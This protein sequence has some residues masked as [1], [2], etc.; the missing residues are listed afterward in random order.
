MNLRLKMVLGSVLLASVVLVSLVSPG[1]AF[2]V[3]ATDS[4]AR[5]VDGDTFDTYANGRVRLADVDAPESYEP[6]FDGATDALEGMIGG[7]MVFLDID[8]ISRTDRFGRLVCV[9]YVRYNSSHVSNVNKALVDQG[10]ALVSDFT[11]NEFKP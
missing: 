6:G 3:D 7:R 5:V 8:D 9:V 1:L 10:W 11:N 4:V 2:E